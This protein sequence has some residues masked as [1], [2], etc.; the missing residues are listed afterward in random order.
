[1]TIRQLS[2][3]MENKPGILNEMLAVLADNNINIASLTVADTDEYGIVRLLVSEPEMAQEKLREKQF[4]VRIH[5]VLSL[6]MD[7]QPGSMYKIMRQFAEAGIS[8]EYVYAFSYGS[9]SIVVFRTN[10]REKAIEV[11]KENKF[12]SVTEEDLR[13]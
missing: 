13:Y 4:T 5:D 2:I 7:P 9:K 3:F 6:E 10:N 8:M 11:I 1:M 12:K